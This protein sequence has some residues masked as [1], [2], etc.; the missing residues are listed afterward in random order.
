MSEF[1]AI[2]E[3]FSSKA[4]HLEEDPAARFRELRKCSF[5]DPVPDEWL[6][7]ISALAKI[8]IFPEEDCLASEEEE[9]NAFYVLLQGAATAYCHD[10]IVGTIDSGE[11]IGEGMFFAGENLSRIATVIADDDIIAAEIEKS[12]ISALQGD[13]R[14]YMDRAL[15][16]SLFKKLRGANLK[17]EELLR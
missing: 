6:H 13:A 3:G 7:P 14:T 16:R 5:F 9:M 2:A 8:R 11:C 17:I 15:L 12:A 4:N 1:D 10:K